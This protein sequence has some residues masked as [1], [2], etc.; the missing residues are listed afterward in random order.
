MNHGRRSA[1]STFFNSLLDF[2]AYFSKEHFLRS[3]L[4]YG[5]FAAFATC[6]SKLP[7]TLVSSISYT[8]PIYCMLL[9]TLILKEAHGFATGSAATMGLLGALVITQPALTDLDIW[10]VVGLIGAILDSLAIV[11]VR[12]LA[13]T[14]GPGQMSLSFMLW[15]SVIG[16]PIAI[17]AW[18]W[19]SPADW[20][21]LLLLAIFAALA[22]VALVRGYA[23]VRLSRAAPFDFIRLTSLAI[24]MLCF[25]T[26]P[27]PA[28]WLGSGLIFCAAS[29]ALVGANMHK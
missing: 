11:M 19:P 2:Q 27:T 3:A 14:A 10:V 23:R 26:T 9:S 8:S 15:S 25:D 12:R 18:V 16:L 24:D 5:G 13:N 22:Q 29:V 17:P 21:L 20:A 4:G 6:S 7:L 28:M 1:A